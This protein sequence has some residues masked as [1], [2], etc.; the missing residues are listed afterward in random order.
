MSNIKLQ[1]SKLFSRLLKSEATDELVQ[2]INR[3]TQSIL[4]N[5]SLTADLDDTAAKELLDWGIACAKMIVQDTTGLNNIEA[6]EA[7]S[8][9]L[10]A[11][12]Q[13]MRSVN[14]W[15]ARQGEMDAEASST[16]L[17]RIIEQATMIYGE[18]FTPPDNE[19]RAA[20]L[21]QQAELTNNPQQMIANLRGLLEKPGDTSV[22]QGED[23]DQKNQE[24]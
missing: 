1:L 9:R 21:R 6:E 22:N 11:T 16:S 20:F 5:E 14:G 8:P 4:E 13:L 12:R 10:R 2:R 7:M 19:Q 17:T 3:V 24:L 23:D 15:V 18:G